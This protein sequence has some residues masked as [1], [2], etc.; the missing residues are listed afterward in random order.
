MSVEPSGERTKPTAACTI[1]MTAS[2]CTTCSGSATV[3]QTPRAMALQSAS[4]ASR[5]ASTLV[6]VRY[7]T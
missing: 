2:V 1:S 5:C 6:T 7:S 4:P 3:S